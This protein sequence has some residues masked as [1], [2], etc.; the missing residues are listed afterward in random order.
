MKQKD[1]TSDA[2]WGFYVNVADEN[3]KSTGFPGPK[4]GFRQP[5]HSDQNSFLSRLRARRA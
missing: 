4:T 3:Q 1:D 5:V 2:F